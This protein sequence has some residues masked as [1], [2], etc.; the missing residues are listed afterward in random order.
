[1]N[2]LYTCPPHPVQL[3]D[4]GIPRY[5]SDEA[6]KYVQKFQ[7]ETMVTTLS[8]HLEHFDGITSAVMC[9]HTNYWQH[10]MKETIVRACDE[11]GFD[12]VYVDQVGNGEQR[13]CA[14]P[15]H[16]HSIN[17]GSFWAEAF[18]KV[19]AEVRSTIQRPSVF[20][21]EGI[22]EEV[23]GAGF[24]IML[25]LHESSGGGTAVWHAVYGGYALATGH[26]V[27]EI[28]PLASGM[29]PYLTTQFMLGGTMGWFTYQ[30]Y[31]KPSCQFLDPSNAANVAYIRKLSDAR[32]AAIDWMMHG[33]LTRTLALNSSSADLQGSCFL[34]DARPAEAASVVCALALPISSEASSTYALSVRPARYGLDASKAVSVSDLQ[35]GAKLG[36]YAAGTEV[37]F[38][39]ELPALSVLLLKLQQE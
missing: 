26:A 7:A 20:M 16:N 12:G 25:G 32:L 11:I 13:N 30:D 37:T 17:G 22:V 29:L 35:T 9:P 27:A 24:D 33:H 19:M 2:S 23:S 14:D 21:T 28:G 10:I 1:M 34:R 38:A 39:S 6:I 4:T 8:P 3:Y 5:T 18:Y 31:C 15:S 36:K